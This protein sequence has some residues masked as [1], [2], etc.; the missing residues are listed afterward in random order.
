M[1]K[2]PEITPEAAT[3]SLGTMTPAMSSFAPKAAAAA[4]VPEL[5]EFVHTTC[6]MQ[7][8]LSPETDAAMHADPASVAS[9]HCGGCG[10]R[11]PVSEFVW[12]DGGA[13]VAA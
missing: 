10:S 5:R 8:Q 9:L 12:A 2:D 7:S 1:P 11:F 13:P 6:R 3:V 4:A